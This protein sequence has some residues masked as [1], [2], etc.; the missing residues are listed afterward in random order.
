M[1]AKAGSGT[2]YLRY[3]TPESRIV[4]AQEFVVAS[5]TTAMD[6]TKVQGMFLKP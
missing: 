2:L 5:G 1:K 6:F 4:G 3:F